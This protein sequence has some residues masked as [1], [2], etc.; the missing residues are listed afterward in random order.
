GSNGFNARRNGLH[1]NPVNQMKKFIFYAL[2]FGA[3]AG[4]CSAQ[5]YRAG[6]DVGP[7]TS[8]ILPG[9]PISTVPNAVISVCAYPANGVPCTNKATTF[10]DATL[11]TPCPS[12]QQVVL[13]GTTSCVTTADGGGNWGVWLTPGSNYSYTVTLANGASA[14]P[15]AISAASLTGGGGGGSPGGSSGQIQYNAAG[16]FGGF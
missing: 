3:F 6:S 15:Y 13:A 10:T 16:S 1:S 4:V 5:G 12:N 8:Y 7:V 11:T 14:G 2:L 9:G